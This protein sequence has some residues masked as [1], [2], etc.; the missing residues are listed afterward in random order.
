MELEAKVVGS[1]KTLIC[2]FKVE[3]NEELPSC[4]LGIVIFRKLETG[5]WLWEI[6]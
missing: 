1:I 5:L 3:H 4:S 6:L 2:A